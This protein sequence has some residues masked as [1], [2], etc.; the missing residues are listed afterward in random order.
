MG[1]LGRTLKLKR[2]H[3]GATAPEAFHRAL[4]G[5]I[6]ATVRATVTGRAGEQ[7]LAYYWG[8][9]ASDAFDDGDWTSS[10]EELYFSFRDAAGCCVMS[11]NAAIHWLD[12]V[13]WTNTDVRDLVDE[14]GWALV[15]VPYVPAF[16]AIAEMHTT[17]LLELRGVLYR[18]VRRSA[19]QRVDDDDFTVDQGVPRLFLADLTPPERVLLEAAAYSGA[20]NCEYCC[21]VLPM[22]TLEEWQGGDVGHVGPTWEAL[23]TLEAEVAS[24]AAAC[25][26]FEQKQWLHEPS[27]PPA[28]RALRETLAGRGLTPP[29]SRLVAMIMRR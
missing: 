29:T 26:L 5:K 6:D 18:V 15:D 7:V 28:L 19:G 1:G 2:T 4:W 13:L 10:E 21:R 17:T 12:M 25:V 8:A 16:K 27:G 14:A 9:S 20:C 3:D 24:A 22:V 11:H 23:D